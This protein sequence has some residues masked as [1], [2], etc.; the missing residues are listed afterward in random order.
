MMMM[1]LLLPVSNDVCVDRTEELPRT[2]D[3]GFLKLEF[4]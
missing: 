1:L 2:A 3:S 4:A